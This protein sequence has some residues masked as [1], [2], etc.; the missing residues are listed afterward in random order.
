MNL[1]QPLQLNQQRIAFVYDENN[2]NLVNEI[3][4]EE[5]YGPRDKGSGFHFSKGQLG[6]RIE[7]QIDDIQFV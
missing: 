1:T 6:I 4:G 3:I 5:G 2:Y 7:G